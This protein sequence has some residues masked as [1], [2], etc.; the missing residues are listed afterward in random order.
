MKSFPFVLGF[1]LASAFWSA[2]QV[3]LELVLDQ[4][5]FL[6]NES[7][8]VKVRIINR[9]G[10]TLQ[11]GQDK[12]WLT[13]TIES[14]EGS[15]VAPIGEVPVTGEQSIDSSMV[16]NRSVDLMPYYDLSKPGR[17]RVTAAIRIKP[18]KEQFISKPKNFEISAGTKIWEQEFGVGTT[19]GNSP[20]VRKY[21]LQQANYVKQL[22]LYVRVTDSTEQR[23]FKVL[24]V[25]PLLSFS[26]PEAR[27]DR[28]SNLHLLFQ[29]GARSFLY[30]V[31]NPDGDLLLRQTHDYAN[32][33]P[34]LRTG[35]DGKTFISGGVRRI[36]PKDIPPPV[37]SASTNDAKTSKP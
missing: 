32:A 5:Q 15:L 18:L 36:T 3:S 23:V 37:T 29:T 25:G 33:R 6:L 1:F 7:L 19:E 21:T 28:T 22:T 14:K 26:R 11:L 35:E 13:F 24:P 27:I 4:E 30:Q 17:Y 2:A 34:V 9:S 16:A 8:P 10:Q 20:E 31:I 12:D